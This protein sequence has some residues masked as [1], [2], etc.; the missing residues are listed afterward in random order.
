[1]KRL[2]PFQLII[3]VGLFS[4]FLLG[5]TQKNC[6]AQ[7][8]ETLEKQRF[9]LIEKIEKATSLLNKNS[10]SQQTTLKDIGTMNKRIKNRK[11]LI[12][13][14]GKELDLI[15][16]KLQSNE[17]ENSY[18]KSR[19][20]TVKTKYYKLLNEAYKYNLSYNKWAFILNAKSINDSFIRWQYLKQYKAYCLESYNYLL[21]T[22]TAV[23]ESTKQLN[24]LIKTREQFLA[25]E[26]SQLA[27]IEEEKEDLNDKLKVLKNDEA[28]LN[29]D[30]DLIKTQRENL[31]QAIEKSILA[32]LGGK[33]IVE[34]ST[35][36]LETNFRNT[37]KSLAWPVT[38]GR[39]ISGFGTQRHPDFNQVSIKNNGIDISSSVGSFAYS[40]HPGKVVSISKVVGYENIVIVQHGNFY[41]VYSKLEKVLVK[42]GDSLNKGDQI[43]LI[44]LNEEGETILH[45]E[46][47]EGKEKQNPSSWLNPRVGL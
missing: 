23:D 28:Q 38:N 45:F 3:R 20:D 24:D 41:T 42:K 46:I 26:Q 43:G 32:S 47:W 37:K 12:E 44:Y 34:E 40:V 27:L 33:T 30:L 4:L 17:L 36:S 22:Q 31:N 29:V 6:H 25:K 9:E 16:N 35:T 11:A 8:R 21:E 39:V 14:Y 13:N 10:T 1:M 5:L 2:F 7:S 15:K 18:L 19:L